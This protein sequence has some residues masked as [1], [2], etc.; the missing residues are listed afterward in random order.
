MHTK[1]YV[2]VA[3]Q[4]MLS[5]A[6]STVLNTQIG[7]GQ[8]DKYQKSG[9]PLTIITKDNYM[10]IKS[11][12]ELEGGEVEFTARLDEEETSFL[13]E[14]AINNLLAMGVTPFLPDNKTIIAEE[15][16]TIN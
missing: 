5:G 16:T 11:T 1:S 12:V 2:K 14:F 4:P 15:S 8:E 13:L 7:S 6:I 10:Q 3:K 9:L